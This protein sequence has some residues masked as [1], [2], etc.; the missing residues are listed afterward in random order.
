MSNH[1]VDTYSSLA[2]LAAAKANGTLSPRVRFCISCESEYIEFRDGK[3]KVFG[4]NL[5]DFIEKY[6]C[7]L[8]FK[9]I[10]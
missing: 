5:A 3:E 6:L 7:D 10:K 8:G 1:K 2:K 9:E 4:A